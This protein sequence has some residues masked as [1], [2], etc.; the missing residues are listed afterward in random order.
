MMKWVSYCEVE[1]HSSYLV[2]QT[3]GC[4]GNI[5][6]YMA[7]FNLNLAGSRLSFFSK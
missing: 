2:S 3:A 1:K 7:R 5:T 4:I 6:E